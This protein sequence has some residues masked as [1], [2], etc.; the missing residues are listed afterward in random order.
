MATETISS[1]KLEKFNRYILTMVKALGRDQSLIVHQ[2]INESFY[3]QKKE[4][5]RLLRE[6]L[7]EAERKMVDVQARVT[8]HYKSAYCIW[9]KDVRWLHAHWQKRIIL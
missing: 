8:E 3:L 9:R 5:F 6:Q 4:E 2:R 1:K 7:E